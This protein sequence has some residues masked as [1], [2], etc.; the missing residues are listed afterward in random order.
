MSGGSAQTSVAY[1]RE[2]NKEKR[3]QVK[4]EKYKNGAFD[5][6]VHHGSGKCSRVRLL[7]HTVW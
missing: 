3:P 7:I 5:E 4:G 1:V 2:D 6:V